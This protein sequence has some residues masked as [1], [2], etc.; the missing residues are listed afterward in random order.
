M[1]DTALLVVDVQND[2]VEGG[3]LACAGGRELAG[4]IAAHVAGLDPAV[5]VVASRDDHAPGS[6]NGGH[7]SAHPDFVD[8]W[9]PHCIHGTAGQEYVDALA[10]SRRDVEVL[11][12]QGRPAYS[13]F[14]GVS[15]EGKSLET[16][17][18][19]AGV[20]ELDICG[21]ATDY[22]VRASAL[23]AARLGFRPR[24]LTHLCVG[25][26][27]ESTARA[28]DEMSRACVLMVGPT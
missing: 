13:A 4:R 9:P 24:L 18:H 16:V 19:D 11:K 25:V 21:I 6:S 7:I 3:S 8:S 28:L 14:E 20:R 17:L 15:A 2:F 26:N 12:G 22:C 5:L 27:G 1:A 10:S 23:D